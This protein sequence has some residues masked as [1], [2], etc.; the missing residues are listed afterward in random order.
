MALVTPLANDAST[1]E[2]I[3]VAM[4]NF[5]ALTEIVNDLIR[6]IESGENPSPAEAKK[7]VADYRTWLHNVLS[8][9]QNLEEKRKKAAGIVHDYAID[10]DAARVEIRGRLARLRAARDGGAVSG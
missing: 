1:D 7:S 5:A 6:R 2:I 8:E 9:R 4:E 3:S 10:F